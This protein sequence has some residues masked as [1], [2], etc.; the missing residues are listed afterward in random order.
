MGRR[1]GYTP[2]EIELINASIYLVFLVYR[3]FLVTI[4]DHL[5]MYKI[6]FILYI[7]GISLKR[8]YLICIIE[9]NKDN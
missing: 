2:V 3:S 9:I 6:M 5:T 8:T 1:I 7:F 4:I